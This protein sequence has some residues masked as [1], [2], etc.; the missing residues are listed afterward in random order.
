MINTISKFEYWLKAGRFIPLVIL[1]VLL[2]LAV[3]FLWKRHLVVNSP[4]TANI[5]L[6][7]GLQQERSRVKEILDGPCD[8]PEI[9]KFRRGEIGP[10]DP[11]SKSQ[12]SKN[13]EKIGNGDPKSQSD[14]VSLLEQS[15]VR[16]IAPSGKNAMIG[17]GF[18]I[19]KDLIVTNQHV[20]ADGDPNN[21]LITSKYLG[22]TP[23]KVTLVAKTPNHEF[24]NPDFALLKVTN[25]PKP[26]QFLPI[27]DDPPVLQN[28][29][30]AGFPGFTTDTDANQTTP[31]TV[32]SDGRV[33]VVQR[34][35]N[36]ISLVIHGAYIS[37]GN[38]GGPLINSCGT[39]VGVNTF[40]RTSLDQK[41]LLAKALYAL[42]ATNLRQFLDANQAKYTTSS[43]QCGKTATTQ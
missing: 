42:S 20:I 18:F 17:T 26:I 23:I 12:N 43:S 31:N 39:L 38:S 28:V 32:Y 35:D 36:G 33:S 27:G 41:D 16:V 34:Q 37:P 8:S 14:I 30:A 13:N 2:N 24:G 22:G 3:Y 40:G 6:I 11:K 9:E 29:Y 21:L 19:S 25:L 7:E 10:L 5:A 1:L 15:T 4:Q